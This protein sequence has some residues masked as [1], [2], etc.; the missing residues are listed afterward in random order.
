MG[1]VCRRCTLPYCSG[2]MAAP[3]N[4]GRAEESAAKAHMTKDGTQER[5]FRANCHSGCQ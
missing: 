1:K 3:A 2:E 4:A 5:C